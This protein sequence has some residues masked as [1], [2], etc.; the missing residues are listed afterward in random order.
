MMMMQIVNL[1]V[2]KCCFCR[3]LGF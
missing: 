1:L 3:C 2:N